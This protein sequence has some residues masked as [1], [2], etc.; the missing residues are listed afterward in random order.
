LF[1]RVPVGIART[2]AD[3]EDRGAEIREVERST[4][5]A[6]GRAE[7]LIYIENQYIT[8]KAAAEALVARMRAMPAL[9]VIVLTSREPGGWLEAGTMGVGRQ[10]F[11]AAFD[12][13]HLRRRIHFLYPF[14][15]GNP[16]DD[17]YE[18]PNKTEDGTFSIHVHAK[19]LIVDDTFLRIGSS[20]LNNRSMGFD[21][22]CDLGL[23]AA[24]AEHRRAIARVRNDLIAEHWGSTAAAVERALA[25]DGPV[26]EALAALTPADGQA[27]P[28]RGVAP[29]P[30]DE[31]P[32]D[33]DIV[34]KLGDPERIVTAERFVEE[35]AGVKDGRPML[36]WALGVLTA[37]ALLI[38]VVILVQQLPFDGAGF[39]ERVSSGIASL[40]GSPWRVPLVLLIFVVGSIVSFPILVMIGATV[41]ALGPL[42]G[43][44]CAAAGSL[45][46]ATATF[47]IGRLIGRRPLRRWLGHKAQ[48]LEKQLAGRGIVTV[49]L[50]RKVPIAP[51]TIVNMLIGASGLPY[52]EFIAGTAIGMLPG[53]AA[54]ALVGDRAMDVWRNPT[55]LNVTLVAAAVA[56]W[57]GVVLGVQYLMNRYAK[58]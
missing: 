56:V 6:I 20:N 42:L 53:I 43:F 33:P 5:E 38:A 45:L 9:E 13:P 39:T 51:F 27:P 54:F 50:I 7:R 18:A 15:R 35:I 31:A 11:M 52:R 40:R 17:E 26:N 30:R 47:Q 2:L 21:T 37:V 46:A 14:A 12:E 4:V 28:P 41:L 58:K 22:E 48:V 44:F 8:A 57:I 34:Q 36:R 23:E 32:P 29:V 16:G 55:P 24:T 19:V 1:E 49:A 3:S 25:S 10:Q